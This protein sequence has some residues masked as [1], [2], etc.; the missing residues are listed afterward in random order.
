MGRHWQKFKTVRRSNDPYKAHELTFTCYH[1]HAFLSRNRTRIW[2]AEAIVQARAKHRFHLWAYV[3]MPEHVHL[4]LWPGGE[5]GADTSDILTS[6]KQSV[7]RRAI[8]HL[9]RHNPDGLHMLATGQKH[10]PYRFWQ[11]GG[12]YDRDFYVGTALRSSVEYIHANPVRRGLVTLA[13]D[14]PWSSARAW[15][16]LGAGPIPLDLASFPTT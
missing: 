15:K 10:A 7:A 11:D 16:G 12:G 14:W 6:I 4:L 13:E 9:K 5:D 3:F 1:G 2:L 8:I